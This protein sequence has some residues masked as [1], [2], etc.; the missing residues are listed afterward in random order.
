MNW[1]LVNKFA[2]NPLYIQGGCLCDAFGNYIFNIIYKCWEMMRV[3]VDWSWR[4][5]IPP[6]SSPS[7]GSPG[8]NRYTLAQM[9]TLLFQCI[10]LVLPACISTS[11]RWKMGR[12]FTFRKFELWR[13]E[14]L[15][16]PQLL[17]TF[18]GAA[19]TE[20]SHLCCVSPPSLLGPSWVGWL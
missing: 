20:L 19:C 5:N 18:L 2:Q 10:E 8:G 3:R 12:V 16:W 4:E 11:E 6:H 1:V 15:T 17:A 14:P 7:S 13:V 9:L